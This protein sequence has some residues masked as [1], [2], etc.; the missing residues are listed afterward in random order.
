M[1]YWDKEK[2]KWRG[3]V[4]RSGHKKQQLFQL[5]SD[6]KEW[7]INQKALPLDR[8]FEETPTEYSLAQWSTEYLDHAKSKYVEKTYAEKNLAFKRFFLSVQPALPPSRL[9]PGVIL[10]H[11]NKEAKERTGN[12]ANKDR[13]NLIAG[14]NWA[15]KYLVGWPRENP[16]VDTERQ[17][18][19]QCPRYV[20]PAEDFW[21]VFDQA[22]EGQDKIMLLAYLHTAARRNELFELR[23]SDVDFQ[24]KRMRLWTKKRK[25]G[26]EHDWITMT[27]ELQKTLEDWY[28]NRTFPDSDF[29]FLC[30]E[31]NNYC[32]DIY[33]H[34]FQ[35][36]RHWFPKLC[37]KADVEVFGFHAI[38]HLSASILD[39]A[40]YPITVIQTLLRHKSAN[41]TALY[42]HKLRGMRE[43]L[44][45]AFNRKSRPVPPLRATGRP[46][47]RIVKSA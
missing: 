38:R 36:R 8:F 16:F 6:A 15:R 41:T 14:W 47:L 43:A 37:G 27:S 4:T 19:E 1:P 45:E 24:K 10:K 34:P 22:K 26:R 40:G 17:H 44:D 5:K 33:G 29:V 25:G 21:K 13:K 35:F 18:A 39:D 3:K 12:A 7:E 28:K 2:K 31:T 23:W 30:E 20:P 46:F 32:K 42:L 9:H 11:F